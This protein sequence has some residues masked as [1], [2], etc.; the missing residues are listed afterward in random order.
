MESIHLKLAGALVL[1]FSSVLYGRVGA[2]NSSTLPTSSL[3]ATFVFGDSLVDPGNNNYLQFALAKANFAHNGMD[4]PQGPTGR[5]CNGRV[6]TDI[7][8]DLIGV[9]YPPPYLAPATKAGNGILQGVNYASAAGGILDASGANYIQRLGMNAQITNFQN[10]LSQLQAQ[11]GSAATADLLG[12]A[13]CTIVF[14][15][16]DFINN[17]LLSTTTTKYQYDVRSYNIYLLNTLDQQL[18]TLYNFGFRK[19]AVSAVGPLGC[20]PDQLAIAGT[21]T[22]IESTNAQVIDFNSGLQSLTTQLTSNHPGAT[23]LYSNVYDVV[24][25]MVQSPAQFGFA[26]NNAGCCGIGTLSGQG[27]CNPVVTPCSDRTKYIFW[28]PYHPTESAN[29]ILGNQLWSGGTDIV[30]PMNIKELLGL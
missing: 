15:S 27:P 20:I 17:Y 9:P 29:I 21:T 23:F 3:P 30:S 12:K 7:I 4:F 28:D 10:T 26:V 5:F 19:F 6:V 8:C 18:T 22:C 14:G 25:Q 16:N 2:Q 13:L 1:C 11:I 24:A